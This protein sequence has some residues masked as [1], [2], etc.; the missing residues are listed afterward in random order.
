M[1]H[2]QIR[3]QFK[4]Y[5]WNRVTKLYTSWILAVEKEK[6]P[7]SLYERN[8]LNNYSRACLQNIIFHI[9]FNRPLSWIFFF[10]FFFEAPFPVCISQHAH[11]IIILA[12]F[13]E[14]NIG[15]WSS[16][17]ELILIMSSVVSLHQYSVAKQHKN[18]IYDD[19]FKNVCFVCTNIFLSK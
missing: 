18:K 9:Q 16:I 11:R 19:L 5:K 7:W 17:Y 4:V 12:L 14:L 3:F 1:I 10:F 6:L 2:L 8:P 13:S 15:T